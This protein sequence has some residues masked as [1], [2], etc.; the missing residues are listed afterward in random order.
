[1]DL[2]KK[3]LLSERAEGRKGGSEK[4]MMGG[5]DEGRKR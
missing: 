4:A 2:L 1:M 5:R 3:L